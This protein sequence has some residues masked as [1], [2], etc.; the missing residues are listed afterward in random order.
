[1]N[2]INLQDIARRRIHYRKK[3]LEY[4]LVRYHELNFFAAL[5]TQ[6]QEEGAE[7]YIAILENELIDLEI[8]NKAH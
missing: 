6:Y 1:M 7:Y 4:S 3:M 5:G 8:K 2:Q